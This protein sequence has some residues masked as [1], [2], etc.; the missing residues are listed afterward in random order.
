MI[1]FNK[2]NIV[3][4]ATGIKARVNYSLGIDVSGRKRVWIYEK[5]CEQNLLK[6]FSNSV[7]N[8]NMEIDY[9][10][11]SK[12]SFFEEHEYY[13]AAYNQVP[14]LNIDDY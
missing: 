13:S 10:E 8:S 12:V 14:V 3:D 7:N 6:I 2:H 9:I 11:K 5:N 1:K 4:T